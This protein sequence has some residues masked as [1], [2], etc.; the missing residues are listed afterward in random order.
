MTNE[1]IA[2]EKWG[3]IVAA[4]ILDRHGTFCTLPPPARHHDIIAH[5]VEHGSP[6]P[7]G[8]PDEQGFITS[9]GGFVSRKLAAKIAYMTG[10]IE[11]LKWPPDLYSEDLW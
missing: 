10:Q 6:T 1:E 11:A 8:L 4:A 7:C 2:A 3:T 9:K 5:M